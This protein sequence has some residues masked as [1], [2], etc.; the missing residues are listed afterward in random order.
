MKG[1]IKVFM[2][3]ILTFTLC[4][5]SAKDTP[6]EEVTYGAIEC[7]GM[8]FVITPE[9]FEDLLNEKIEGEANKIGDCEITETD[10][11]IIYEYELRDNAKLILEDVDKNGYISG[12]GFI[13]YKDTQLREDYVNLV[14]AMF[15][16]EYNVE[17]IFDEMNGNYET[18]DYGTQS[19]SIE[20]DVGLHEIVFSAE[21]FEEGDKFERDIRLVFWVTPKSHTL[22]AG[23]YEAGVDLLAW[24]YDIMCFGGSGE[25]SI[26]GGEVL[27]ERFS[28]IDGTSRYKNVKLKD[29]DIIKISGDVELR[30]SPHY[31]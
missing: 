20:K 14:L 9:Q 7:E 8:N 5:C 13:T 25:C 6:S 11:G 17:T 29:G 18:T 15:N 1:K 21:V 27:E 22:T 19:A 28:L 30:F 24:D 31:Y 16:E 2:C 23:T 3:M 4:G 10:E 12:G 26:N